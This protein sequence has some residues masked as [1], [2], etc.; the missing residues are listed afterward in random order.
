[1]TPTL[2]LP[3]PVSLILRWLALFVLVMLV[4]W[5]LLLVPGAREQGA[6]GLGDA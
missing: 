6:H 4:T 3:R 5:G 1:M 2:Y